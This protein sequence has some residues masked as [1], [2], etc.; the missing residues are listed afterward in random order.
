MRLVYFASVREAV[1]LSS[2]RRDVPENV[3]TIA[4]LVE[5][6]ALQSDA[7]ATAFR[8]PSRLRFALDQNM[9]AADT[10]L[11]DAQEVAIFPPVTGG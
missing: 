1:G 4:Q 10:M 9:V 7:H 6:L 8:D 11:G 3:G 5:Y 2:E